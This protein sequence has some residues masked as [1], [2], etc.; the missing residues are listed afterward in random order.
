M[1]QFGIFGLT[2]KLKILKFKIY[3]YT[4]KKKVVETAEKTEL[5]M[6][7]YPLSYKGDIFI[8]GKHL[9]EGKCLNLKWTEMR[10]K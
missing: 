6:K 4:S 5:A 2:D 8:I 3:G 10:R 1:A 7:L 9:L